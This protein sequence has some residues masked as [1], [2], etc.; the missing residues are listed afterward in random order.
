MRSVL[1]FLNSKFQEVDYLSLKD[2]AEWIQVVQ[3]LMSF[4]VLIPI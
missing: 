3:I 1:N 2:K 4:Q